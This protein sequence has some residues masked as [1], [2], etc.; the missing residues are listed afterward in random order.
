MDAPRTPFAAVHAHPARSAEIIPF[1]AQAVA[2]CRD[3]GDAV[4]LVDAGGRVLRY[5]TEAG[6]HAAIIAQHVATT[7]QA[8]RLEAEEREIARRAA[9]DTGHWLTRLPYLIAGALPEHWV[10]ACIGAASGSAAYL[11]RAA[12]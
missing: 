12:Q 2:W 1:P 11:I 3:M 8:Q 5:R 7:E 4:A 10:A 6:L 9:F